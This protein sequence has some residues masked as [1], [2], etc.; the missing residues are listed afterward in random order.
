LFT[1]SGVYKTGRRIYVMTESYILS[2]HGYHYIL[3][4]IGGRWAAKGF[5]LDGAAF[6]PVTVNDPLLVFPWL[7]ITIPFGK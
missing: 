5:T 6:V 7:S 3:P 4:S 1:L 2:Y